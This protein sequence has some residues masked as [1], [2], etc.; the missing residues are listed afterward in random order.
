MAW[1]Y[2]F[3]SGVTHWDRKKAFSGYTLFSY[4]PNV[5]ASE[6][7]TPDNKVHLLDMQGKPVHSWSTT[8]P[9]MYSVLQPNGNLVAMLHCAKDI[10]GRPGFGE[11]RMGGASGM[12]VELDW[13]SNILFEYFDP[14][15]HHDFCKM[16]N[17]NYIY[18]GW[19]KMPSELT[20]KVR[21]GQKGT[22]HKDG[23]MFGD[24]YREINSSGQTVWEWSGLEHFDPD[25]DIIGPIHTREAWTHVN[26]VDSMP[27]GNILSGA[28][29]TDG[30]FIID[31]SSGEISWRWGNVAYLDSETDH[32]EYRVETD[33][34][35]MGGPHD[36]HIIAK[37]LPGEGNM[38]IYDNGQY[39]YRSRALEVDIDNG[40]VIW[41][42]CSGPME[43]INGR[44][45]FSP[46]LGGADRLP[47]GNTMICCGANGVIFEVTPEKE[48]VWHYVRS[49]PNYSGMFHWAI[50]R[51]YRFAPDYCP[52]LASL[53]SPE[54]E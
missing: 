18:V 1:P 47:N 50:Y 37:G 23:V 40:E 10:D 32:V 4:L 41:E 6:T 44:T 53:P 52:Q 35:T 9:V 29:H 2:I 27:D 43:S 13:D 30:V 22:E 11:Y 16:D 21:G 45:H 12:V 17:G 15:M 3:Q 49:E 31:R 20:R 24:Y 14:C 54:G 33:P 39:A 28:R 19:E 7:N 5:G 36:G 42:S 38:L 34:K 8:F 51:A 26:D 48:I 25:I 46:Y